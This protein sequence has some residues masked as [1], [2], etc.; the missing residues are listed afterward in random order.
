MNVNLH[1]S[2]HLHQS[3]GSCFP[4]TEA[5]LRLAPHSCL[6]APQLNSPKSHSSVL[7]KKKKKKSHAWRAVGVDWTGKL[8][9]LQASSACQCC[10]V[11]VIPALASCSVAMVMPLHR[12]GTNGQK[13]RLPA[14]SNAS[15]PGA[16]AG[17]GSP[18]QPA[19]PAP[20][21]AR[22]AGLSS[23][24]MHWVLAFGSADS[25]SVRLGLCISPV[26][27]DMH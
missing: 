2:L 20:C 8:T 24:A 22:A 19:E 13:S 15:W 18:Q 7:K 1:Q 6:V 26:N 17:A 25:V 3:L 10:T 9:W 4:H 16:G 27:A 12:R 14:A 23:V 5:F 11:Q 21:M